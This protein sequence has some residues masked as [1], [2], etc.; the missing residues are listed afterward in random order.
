MGIKGNSELANI[1]RS[2]VGIENFVEADRVGAVGM[3]NLALFKFEMNTIERSALV[4]GRRI[5]G[6]LALYGFFNREPYFSRTAEELEAFL[7][8]LGWLK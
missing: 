6:N 7:R 2:R 3:D 8:G 5:V 4:N 1:A